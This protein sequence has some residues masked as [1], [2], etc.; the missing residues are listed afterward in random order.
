MTLPTHLIAGMII[1][2]V[3]GNFPTAIAG[4]LLIDID[5]II[6]YYKHGIL[7][8]P[9][10]LIKYVTSREDPWEDQRNI[11]HNIIVWIGISVLVAILKPEISIAFSLGYFSHLLLDALDES[12][13][14]PLFPTKKFH[15]RG[16][17]KYLSKEEFLFF[18]FCLLIFLI[19]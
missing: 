18:T 13:F 2:K 10:E 4:A 17:V 16:P 7:F 12:E 5:H 1:G 9:R 19:L 6:S 3:T 14:Y 8:K 11:L 15:F